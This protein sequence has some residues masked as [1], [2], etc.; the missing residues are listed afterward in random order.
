MPI[1]T[2]TAT[3]TWNGSLAKGEG[4]VSV[5]SEALGELPVTWAARTE[6]PDGKTSP[7]ELIAAAHATCFS[8]ALALT[9]GERHTPPERIAVEAKCTLDEVDGAP[10]ITVVELQ[11]EAAVPDL[12]AAGFSDA[13]GAA[14]ELCPV[15]NALKGGVDVRVDGQLA[16]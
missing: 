13:L 8:M 6:R 15:S 12:D 14:N 10:R 11:V 9:L 5:G 1:A 4:S 2:R 7:E 3:T 16:S